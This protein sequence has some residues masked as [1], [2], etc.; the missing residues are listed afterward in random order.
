MS[1]ELEALVGH[2]YVVGGRAISAPPPGVLVEV[3]P[4]KAAR[5]READYV[6]V[7]V[8]PS[9]DNPGPGRFYEQMAQLAAERYFD[10]SGSVTA[11]LRSLLN[12]LNKDLY[13]HNQSGK[14]P[15]EASILCAVL[16]G[17]ELYVGRV[18]S[19]VLLLRND[20]QVVTF[21]EDLSSDEALFR[22]PLGV[23]PI[24]DTRMTRY[25]VSSGTRMVLGDET[26]AELDA[27]KRS[28]ALQA[29]DI[30]ALL[31]A[32]KDLAL[33]QLTLLA[34]E[35]VPPDVPAPIPVREGQSTAELTAPPKRETPADAS[36]GEPRRSRGSRRAPL[37]SAAEDVEI[38]AKSGLGTAV[39]GAARGL[40]VVG[41]LIDLF[42]PP[43][44]A[45]QRGLLAS[46]LA[47]GLVL[48]LPVAIV[49]LVIV[50]WLGGA[51]VSEFEACVAEVQRTAEQARGVSANDLDNTRSFWNAVLV[52]I[53]NCETLRP[54]ATD[55]LLAAVKREGQGI[56]DR[57]DR[58]TRRTGQVVTTFQQATLTR[59]T[60]QGL[61]LYVLDGA[62]DQV[63]R[64]Q[65]DGDGVTLS[66]R[67]AIGP[68]RRD[69]VTDGLIIGDIVDIAYDELNTQIV[70]VGRSGVVVS[71]PTRLPQSC[72]ATRLLASENWV[73]PVATTFYRGTLYI[74][75]PGANQIWRYQPSGG[76]FPNAPQ[77]YFS[78]QRPNIQSAVD[79]GIDT[80]GAVYILRGDGVIAKYFG[81]EAQAFGYGGFEPSAPPGSAT[82]MFLN[83]SPINPAIYVADS[84][85]R[86]IYYMSQAGTFFA[87]YRTFDEDQFALLA[88]VVAEPSLNVI[89]AVSGNSLFALQGE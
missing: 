3:S 22:P 78:G 81:A 23:Q 5:G 87:T 4:K 34:A 45:G 40:D 20:G 79:F 71:C 31:A 65:L 54:D 26:L 69:A 36:A 49:G 57:L 1:F 7:V 52:Q 48:L 51:P 12:D 66:S 2:L 30:N 21:P 80:N 60:M 63:Y 9:G 84:R 76:V 77:D 82:A 55:P 89:Y 14:R 13:D 58:I 24:P 86:T 39:K 27:E 72:E 18:G 32:Y 67:E 56:I 43:P 19:A 59:V 38:R 73:T 74:L 53:D 88:D 6:F 47:T 44:K 29:A 11:G 83:S 25:T 85:T 28:A 50:F 15:Y 41:K 75:D 61:S 33:L 68:M 37:E 17:A 10:S 42:F 8:L 16:R 62:N 70:A 64:V 35:F 46:P